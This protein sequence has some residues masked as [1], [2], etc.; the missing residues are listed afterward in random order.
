MTDESCGPDR[1]DPRS[2]LDAVTR[3]D[4]AHGETLREDMLR[5]RRLLQRRR[6]LG[7]VGTAAGA[8]FALGAGLLSPREA[9]AGGACVPDPAET[10]GPFPADGTNPS[11]GI[12]NDILTESGVVRR[13]IRRSFLTSDT[14]AEGV[15]VVLKLNVAN[16]SDG[17]VGASGLA[18]YVWQC[19]RDGQY[20]L[21]GAPDE[22]YLR[23]VSVTSLAGRVSFRTI[24]PACYGRWPHIHIEV[25]SSLAEATNGRNAILTTQLAMP[26]KLSREIYRKA[27]GYGASVFNLERTSLESD[28]VFGTCTKKQR[29]LMTPTF[30]GDIHGGFVAEVDLNVTI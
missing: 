27:P 10:A 1:S 16:A 9:F 21:Y 29:Q 28:L 26:A 30:L 7:L 3:R 24:F 5:M 25:F 4:N 15:Q 11:Q 8:A 20:S 19:D 23:G 17:C 14:L 18:I 12:T 13:D 22:S 6:A 2:A